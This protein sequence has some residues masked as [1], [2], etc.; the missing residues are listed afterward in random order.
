MTGADPGDRAAQRHLRRTH[1]QAGGNKREPV[2][3]LAIKIKIEESFD[4]ARLVARFDRRKV[5]HRGLPNE[6]DSER[7]PRPVAQACRATRLGTSVSARILSASSRSARVWFAVTQARKQM[8][9][10]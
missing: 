8:R 3:D 5:F 6:K 1:S 9:S 10:F 2:T 4:L 7:A